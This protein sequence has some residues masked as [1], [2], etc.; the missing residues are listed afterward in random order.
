MSDDDK[1]KGEADG[2]RSAADRSADHVAEQVEQSAR[3]PAHA[4][5]EVLRREGEEEMNRPLSALWWSGVAAGL[6]LSLSLLAQGV[7]QAH[8]PD[9]PWRPL[10]ASLGY[11][12]GFL[13]AVM[14]RHQLFTENT[15]TAVLPMA[16]DFKLHNLLRTGRCGRWCSPPTSWA[17]SSPRSSMSSRP[18]VPA[19]VKRE[20]L[21]IAHHAMVLSAGEMF[22]RAIAAGFIIAAMVWLLPPA[23]AAQFPVVILM[24][25]LIA[26]AE[27][28]HI[29][30]GSLEAFLLLLNGQMGMA[31]VTFD[32]AAPVLAGNIVG[33]TLLFAVISYAQ[34]AKEIDGGASA[35]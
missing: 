1:V 2:D 22:C 21:A 16:A 32:F 3:L 23:Q 9:A 31:A 28:A 29:V 19:E 25:W 24:T 26:A 15:L 7:L 11:T 35:G 6:S 27:L 33:G 12:V 13:V 4:I 20:M 5:Y 30:A 14:A 17:P 34:V 8:L 18:I 10:V